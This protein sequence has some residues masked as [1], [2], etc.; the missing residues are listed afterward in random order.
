VRHSEDE[1]DLGDPGLLVEAED[2]F[3]LMLTSLSWKANTDI[4]RTVLIPL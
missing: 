1:R 3:E 4:V 2:L